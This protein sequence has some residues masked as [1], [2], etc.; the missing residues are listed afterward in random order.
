MPLVTVTANG[1]D[2]A[3]TDACPV[4]L[5]RDLFDFVRPDYGP[6]HLHSCLLSFLTHAQN[7]APFNSELADK[8]FFAFPAVFQVKNRNHDHVQERGGEKSP[9]N[10]LSHGPLQL[11]TGDVS[12]EEG[13]KAQSRGRSR[14]ENRSKPLLGT[15]P[16]P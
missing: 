8:D 16:H 3:S 1:I 2:G 4:D 9:Q 13:D 7:L 15:L 11:F 14:H 6:N 12:K 5:A 10:H